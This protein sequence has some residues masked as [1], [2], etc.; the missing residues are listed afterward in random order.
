MFL[1]RISRDVILILPASCRRQDFGY[2]AFQLATVQMEVP[3]HQKA[4]LA[5]LF[6]TQNA[7]NTD[8]KLGVDQNT[9]VDFVD[10]GTL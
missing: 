4:Q 5:Y 1:L 9:F 6:T 3:E 10:R 2:P 7:I 8:R